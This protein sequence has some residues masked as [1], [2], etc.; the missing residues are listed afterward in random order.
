MKLKLTHPLWTH[1]PAFAVLVYLAVRLDGAGPLP[2]NAAIHFDGQGMPN[3]Y[4]S[5]WTTFGITIAMSVLFIVLG[6]IGDE[7]WAR[8]EKA[9]TFNWIS[10]FDEVIIGFLAGTSIGYLDYLTK[11]QSLFNFPWGDILVIAG[12]AVVLA[13]ILELLRPFHLYARPVVSSDIPAVEK[14]VAEKI[15][16]DQ[17]FI[18]W[19]SQNPLWMKVITIVLPLIMLVVAVVTWFE[20]WW[21]SV[22]LLVLGILF[23]SLYGGMRTLVTRQDISVRLGLWGFRVLRISMADIN[24]AELHEFSPL[25]DFGGYGIRF[26]SQMKAYFMSGTAGLLITTNGGKK[27]L[28]G[29]SRPESLVAVTR[30]LI[31]RK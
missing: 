28:I 9:K 23:M 30:A 2:S 11:N 24:S 20:I 14:E 8:S 19:D 6:I 3:G 15:K 17:P 25:S 27:Y 7:L 12:A 13:V 29:S 26:N 16:G 31:A 5:P 10:L 21:V 18:Y 4:G 22:E 1:I